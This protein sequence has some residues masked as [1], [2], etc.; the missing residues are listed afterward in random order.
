MSGSAALE[1]GFPSSHST[2]AVSVA[3]YALLILNF[4]EPDILPW[5]NTILQ[6][7]SYCYGC[8]IVV[9]RL[10]CGMHGFLDVIIGSVLGAAI[11]MVQYWYGQ[12]LDDYAHSGSLKNIMII[13]LIILVLVRIHPEPADDCPC[14]D[15]SVAF[16]GVIIGIEYGN[17][18]F[19]KTDYAVSH[20]VPATV[21]FDIEAMGWLVATARILVGVVTI[22]AWREI[23]KPSLLR[24]LPPIFRV[25]EALGL[26]LPR[27][28]FKQA[29][30][31]TR[32]PAQYKDD[33][34]VIPSFSQIPSL[35]RRRRAISIGPQ[36]E[37]D[38]YETLA[39]RE[40]RRRASLSAGSE[41]FSSLSKPSPVSQ[42]APVV[43]SADNSTHGIGKPLRQVKSELETYESMMGTGSVN[44]S[45]TQQELEEKEMFSRLRKPRVRY[46][47]EVVTKLIVYAGIGWL[48]VEVNPVL[49]SLV[50]LAP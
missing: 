18:H 45:Q 48:A 7:V 4:D 40:K 12:W 34:H 13:I 49:F 28:F 2:N 25:V 39:Y 8:S 16:A 17:W 32:V 22:F 33:D 35:I 38:V 3:I 21:P 30:E 1:Y 24:L 19:A 23:M 9:G 43:P 14:F 42:D 31:Y 27:K 37:A 5:S 10:Y 26:D 46:D 11:S 41:T 47:V 15:D 6:A 29:S 36:S 20:P 44:G 50:G